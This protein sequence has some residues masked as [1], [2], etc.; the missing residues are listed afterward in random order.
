[1]IIHL[2][3]R[4]TQE[5]GLPPMIPRIVAEESLP[6]WDAPLDLPE[7]TGTWSLGRGPGWDGMGQAPTV[8]GWHALGHAGKIE[9]VVVA[10]Y[11]LLGQVETTTQQSG[12]GSY[13]SQA[14]GRPA[15]VNVYSVHYLSY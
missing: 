11:E 13:T 15:L 3:G 4:P 2:K 10:D 7:T 14:G 12:V 8:P 1:M 9:G 6:S 5:S